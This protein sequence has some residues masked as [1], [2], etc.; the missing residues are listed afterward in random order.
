[1]CSF[2]GPSTPP[3]PPPPDNSA[4]EEAARES[5]RRMRLEQAQETK[6]LKEEAFENR[7]QAYTGKAGR[8]SLLSGPR[9]GRGFALQDDMMSKKTLG[10]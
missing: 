2:S 9:G 5:R 10:A 3:P 8:A 1:M 6:R 7:L 4:E